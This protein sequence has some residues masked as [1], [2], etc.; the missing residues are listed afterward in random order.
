MAKSLDIIDPKRDIN[1]DSDEDRSDKPE[2]DDLEMKEKRGGNGVFYLILGIIAILVA[3]GAALYIL[4]MDDSSDKDTSTTATTASVEATTTATAEESVSATAP[5]NPSPEATFTYTD[6]SI[7]IANGNGI[8]G[9]AGRIEKILQDKGY[10]IVST[11]NAS[12]TYAESIIYFKSGQDDL[13]DAI[14]SDL[15]DEYSFTTEVADSVVGSY[16][17][18][19]VLGSK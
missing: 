6:E 10:E 4:F 1:N 7:R 2:G 9:E 14:K 16:D 13:A 17:A 15:S 8:S 3:T 18:V 12:R 11:G 19:V 5:A